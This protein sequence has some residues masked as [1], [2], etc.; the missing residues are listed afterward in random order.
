MFTNEYA[1]TTSHADHRDIVCMRSI[2][3][4]LSSDV[5][6]ERFHGSKAFYLPSFLYVQNRLL[7]PSHYEAYENLQFRTPLG[8]FTGCRQDRHT[9][10]I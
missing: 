8:V 7:G 4:I 9:H 1:H 6:P 3:R 2:S 5:E 10:P